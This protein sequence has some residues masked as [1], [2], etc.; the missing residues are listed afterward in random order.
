MNNEPG[1]GEVLSALAEGL[2]AAAAVR[3]FGHG[4]GTIARWQTR[5]GRHADRLHDHLFRRL[6]LPHIHLDEI[7]T[8]LFGRCDG[9]WVRVALDPLT[10]IV[11]ATH[12]G[13]RTQASAHALIHALAAR[14]RPGC[15]PL[16]TRDGLR[17]D[18]YALTV[19][20]GQWPT[21]WSTGRSRRPTGGGASC[22]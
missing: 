1:Q 15:V 22:A 2:D 6:H 5:A 10:K 8:R 21:P 4:E 12:L 17:L 13:P 11:P 18:Y 14:L 3:V 20:F 7:C 16:F 9:L 19:H